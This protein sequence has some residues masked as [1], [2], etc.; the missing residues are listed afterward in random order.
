MNKI[1]LIISVINIILLTHQQKIKSQEIF[2]TIKYANIQ[3]EYL[4]SFIK[5]N[6]LNGLSIACFTCDNIIWKDFFGES[7]YR[8]RINDSTLFSI[9]STSKN[10]TA[11]AVMFAVQDGLVDLDTPITKYLPDF[12][13]NSCF[14]SFP[15]QKITLR[16]LLSHTAGFT[17]E[18]PI[19]NNY[20]F[21]CSSKQEHWS[22]I[23]DTWLKFP[24][25]SGFSYSNLGFDLAA[26][27]I[28][29]VSGIK[30]E[31]YLKEKIFLPLGMKHTTVDDSEFVT[32]NNKTEGTMLLLKKKHYKIPLIGSGAVYSSLNDMV[33]YVQ[34]QLHF[35]SVNGIQ[36]LERKYLEEM[37]KYN[38]NDYGL[39]T[40]IVGISK[41]CNYYSINLK[42]Q[43][44]TYVLIHN[45]DGFGYGSAMTWFPEYNLGFVVLGNK[46]FSYGNIIKKPFEDF[47]QNNHKVEKQ[48]RLT[49]GFIPYY[50]SYSYARRIFEFVYTEYEKKEILDKVSITGKYEVLQNYK[51]L[52]WY[53]R[54]LRFFRIKTNRVIIT[55]DGG[56]FFMDGYFGFNQLKEYLPGLYF[57]KDGEA[58]DVRNGRL[59]YRNIK[60]KK[61]SDK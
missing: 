13:I 2:D 46:P 8:K 1:G 47:M 41:F 49:K 15:E 12:K 18:A 31:Q 39:G 58:F 38:T 33:K 23:R 37:Y 21:T 32:S 5:E 20:D 40:V 60:L 59:T 27:I 19:G 29:C 26:Q 57:T 7:T 22:S 17:H 24:A 45:G 4:K 3:H 42:E 48:D 14:E 30:Y 16:M 56:I 52:N 55:L 25:G 34:F 61:Y 35:G 53:N 11:M 54:I 9:Q 51:D 28:E 44:D 10:F 50:K 43:F 6:Q 36:I